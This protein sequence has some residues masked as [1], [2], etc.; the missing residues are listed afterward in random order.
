MRSTL[1]TLVVLA[2]CLA[3]AAP[4]L[5]QTTGTIVGRV[6]YQGKPMPGVT[7]TATSPAMQGTR[8][9]IT[10]AS[11]DFNLPNLP[12]GL[13]TLTYAMDGFK[14]LTGQVKV[15]LGQTKT[16]DVTMVPEAI[17]EEITV[18]GR[19]ETVSTDVQGS[20]TVDYDTIEKLPTGRTPLAAVGLAAG[21]T[22]TGPN[23]NTVIAGAMSYQNLYTLNGVVLN[24]NVR[25]QPFNMFIEDAIEETQVVTSGVSAEYGRFGGGVVNVVTKSGGNEFSGSFRVS[26]TNDAWSAPTPLTTDQIDKTNKVYEATFG[27]YILKDRLW[28]FTAGRSRELSGSAQLEVYNTPFPTNDEE[29]RYEIKLTGSITPQH[30]LSAWYIDVSRDQT[31]DFFDPIPPADFDNIDPSRSLPLKG[32]S[33]TYT[34][35][36]SENFFVEALWSKRDF[37]FVDSGGDDRSLE[38]GTPIW[39]LDRWTLFNAP[40]FCGVCRPEERDNKNY[41]AKGSWFLSTESMGSHDLVFGFDVFDDIRKSDNW[42]SASGYIVA[43]FVPQNYSPSGPLL[44]LPTYGGFIIWGSVLEESQGTDFYTKSAYIND[45]WRATKNLTINVGLRYDKN[46]GTDAGGAKV[47]DDSRVSP[48][49]GA[50]WDI[51]GDGQWIVNASYGRYVTAIANTVADAGAAAG[52]PTWAGYLYGGPPISAA[53]LGGNH[54]ALA[55]VFDWFFNVYGGPSNGDLRFWADIPGLSPKVASSLASPY[56]DEYAIG[57]SKRL[58]GRGVLRVDYIRREYG[59]FYV[60]EIVPNRT[61]TDPNGI[62]GTL[63]LAL[64]KNENDLLTRTYD[65]LLT[66]FQYQLSD[67]I[68]IGGNWTWSHTYGNVTGETGGSGPITSGVREYQEYKDPKWNS[69]KGDLGVD[70]RHKIQAWLIWDLISTPHHSLSFSVLQSFFSGTPYSAVGSIPEDVLTSIV[71]DPADLG[72]AGTPGDVDYFFTPRGHFTTDDITRTDIS[73]N[74][75][76]FFE[77]FGRQFE[78]FIQPEILNVFNQQNAVSVNTTVRTARNVDYLAAFDPFTDVPIECPPD[79][80]PAEC[81]NMGA[82]W[83][84]GPK[85]GKPQSESDYQRPRTF[86]VSLGLRF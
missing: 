60:S 35:V 67:R 38:G 46:D 23:G 44:E 1:R 29:D 52:Q 61:I 64:I 82:N 71:G 83:Q 79:K 20:D 65:G 48:R 84:K 59:D 58:G 42:Q 37:S 43:P 49:L 53:E 86:R 3:L 80:S 57:I 68:Q 72:Y 73:F 41:W 70:Q 39:D 30:R 11:G 32:K 31:N 7:V 74:Y 27:G 69:P 5:A 85:F 81:K 22:A 21:T 24:E 19:Y 36:L 17:T 15:T 75:S 55:A 66:R 77:A 40:L 50:S 2:A 16:V 13:Y 8:V 56:G 10:G 47:V 54:A 76:F 78:A 9:A 62:A 25:G 14:T 45:T 33:L 63:D 51:F 34:G 28:F 26:L 6:T 18:T 4:A 12:P